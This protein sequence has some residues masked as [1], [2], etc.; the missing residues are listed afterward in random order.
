MAR[1]T[2]AP[3]GAEQSAG[4]QTG[5]GHSPS[6]A[7]SSGPPRAQG[8]GESVHASTCAGPECAARR[9]IWICLALAV[10]TLATFGRVAGNGF[11]NFD[12]DA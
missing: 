12:D 2:A 5:S 8:S 3:D 7:A 10:V 6:P 11:V 1:I 4:S 9:T